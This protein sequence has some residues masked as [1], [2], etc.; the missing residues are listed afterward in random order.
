MKQSKTIRGISYSHSLYDVAHF[1][2]VGSSVK[3]VP[4]V[5]HVI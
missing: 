3:T 5:E 2:L 4:G 1:V